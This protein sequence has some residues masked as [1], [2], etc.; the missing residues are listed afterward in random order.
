[1]AQVLTR[2]DERQAAD[3]AATCA[4]LLSLDATWTGYAAQAL[5]DP[6]ER[7]FTLAV[8][9]QMT[10]ELA[11]VQRDL[12]L[13]ERLVAEVRRGFYEGDQDLRRAISQLLSSPYHGEEA[14]TVLGI[15]SEAI[16]YLYEAGGS[17]AESIR[18]QLQALGD[19]DVISGDLGLR[20]RIALAITLGVAMI[21]A[22][23]AAPLLAGA[24]VGA[25]ALEALG[26]AG[27]ASLGAGVAAWIGLA[28]TR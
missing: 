14:S 24:A 26:I 3:L 19:G 5:E 18:R 20:A 13:A 15:A 2:D 17:E 9:Q 25:A 1:M 21:G 4:R 23:V 27:G 10:Q 6:G 28:P 11:N 7:A 8:G 22:T 16:G 12:P